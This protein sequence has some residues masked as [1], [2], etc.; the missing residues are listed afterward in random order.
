MLLR[1][2]PKS[3]RVMPSLMHIP[4]RGFESHGFDQAKGIDRNSKPETLKPSKLRITIPVPVQN[5]AMKRHRNPKNIQKDLDKA[6]LKNKTVIISAKNTNLNHRK[7]QTYGAFDKLPLISDGWHHRKSIGDYFTINPFMSPDSTSFNKEFQHPPTFSDY[8]LDPRLVEALTKCGFTKTTNIQHEAIPKMI[9]FSDCHTLI[10]AETGNGKTLAFLV[11]IL[12]HILK[13]KDIEEQPQL[14]SPYGLVV[15]PG[16]ELADQIGSVAENLCDYLGLKVSVLKGGQVRK[17]I[18]HGPREGIDLVVGSQGGLVKLFYE[19][20]LKRDR[21]STIALDEIDTLLDDTF[22][23]DLVS[24]LKKFGRSGQSI[25]TGI[26]ILMAGATFP[27]NF[28]N[29]LDEVMD[30]QEVLKVST[31]NIHRMLFHVPQKFIRVSPAKKTEALLQILEKDLGKKKKILIFSNKA[32]TSDFV[33]MF[34]KENN[35]ECVNFNSN[36]QYQHRADILE[37]FIHREVN[38]MSCTDLMSRGIDTNN[39]SH[40]INYD[41]P[42]NPAD[43]IHR[44]GRVGRVGG[45]KNGHVTSLVDNQGGV[46]VLQ[47]LETS[48][49]KNMEIQK[50]NNNIIR[51]IQ[52]RAEKKGH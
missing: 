14:N 50:V 7:S 43:Y 49:R 27:T 19:G 35:I 34:L 37:R 8:G 18:L 42:L 17:Q 44:V 6:Q 40:V 13:M 11:P 51:I 47:N 29:Y 16:R 20:Y 36:H 22:K 28:D 39:V 15:T 5:R 46:I 2:F 23:D 21:V 4:M 12:N 9:E 33:Q 26:T 1:L 32:S 24:F 41:F 25:V 30:V 48:V 3:V 52:N 45:V 10:A 31:D 38:I